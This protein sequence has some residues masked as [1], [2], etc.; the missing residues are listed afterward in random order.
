MANKKIFWE[1]IVFTNSEIKLT[2]DK[3]IKN[4]FVEEAKNLLKT[5]IK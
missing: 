1:S 2:C 3:S 5:Y 4:K